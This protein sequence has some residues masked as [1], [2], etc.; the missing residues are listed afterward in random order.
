MDT[1]T[2]IFVVLAVAMIAMHLRGH[3][4]HG[5]HG[6]PRSSDPADGEPTSS[7]AA[8]SQGRHVHG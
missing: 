4:G 5:G 1:G 3:G 8:G 2:I 6:R 7:T